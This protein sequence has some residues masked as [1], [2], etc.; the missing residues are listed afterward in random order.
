M[1]TRHTW[2]C[3]STCATYGH[4]RWG[5]GRGGG[6]LPAATCGHTRWGAGQGG[7][8]GGLPAATC[9]PT[10]VY[11]VAVLLHVKPAVLLQVIPTVGVE[12]EDGEKQRLAMLRHL[13]D[14]V[15]QTASKAKFLATM[16]AG[17]TKTSGVSSC[18]CPAPGLHVDGSRGE[19]GTAGQG[20][21]VE[22]GG[23][24]G[25]EEGEEG[26][27]GHK[28]EGGGRGDEGEGREELTLAAGGEEEEELIVA[29]G[30]DEED[31]GGS[32]ATS[33]GGPGRSPDPAR[34]EEPDPGMHEDPDPNR[35][36][37]PDPA[38]SMVTTMLETAAVSAAAL[39]AE[40]QGVS[41]AEA[42]LLAVLD[43]V[44]PLE[45]VQSLLASARGDPARALNAYLDR[46][47]PPGAAPLCAGCRGVAGRGG[48]SQG[49][50]P[51]GPSTGRGRVRGRKQSSSP[52][53]SRK[54]STKSTSISIRYRA[55]GAGH[56]S[57]GS[58]LWFQGSGNRAQGSG[59]RVRED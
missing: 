55:Q 20:A 54:A 44:L 23:S 26:Q 15:D 52:A 39:P 34:H 7:R 58:G 9:I 49:A 50:Q 30:G 12:G 16:V 14:L 31:R 35:H 5:A 11:V 47:R 25:G 13:G 51:G 32:A 48:G 29:A 1:S 24:G 59:F 43:G 4:T 3:G 6:G 33:G 10:R 56:R 37:D 57:Q 2:S 19:G 45:D 22:G 46:A 53:K 21:A 27:G 41:Q 8:A 36:E 40:G 17:K 18:S 38:P 28:E 42:T